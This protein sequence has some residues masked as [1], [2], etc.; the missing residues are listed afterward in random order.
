MMCYITWG[1]EDGEVGP[2]LWGESWFGVLDFLSAYKRLWHLC[3]LA[4]ASDSKNPEL[5][6]W[7]VPHIKSCDS[8]TELL[9]WLI[10]L[11]SKSFIAKMSFKKVFLCLLFCFSFWQFFT[12]FLVMFFFVF[13]L[14]CF[15][16]LFLSCC[17]KNSNFQLFWWPAV[18]NI[19]T[20]L[21]LCLLSIC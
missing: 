19:L 10:I 6:Y 21:F 16:L 17:H 11:M 8:V 18:W 9:I 13:F 7:M 2:D 14:K 5:Y 15:S 12:F 1:L 20:F 4:G 3:G